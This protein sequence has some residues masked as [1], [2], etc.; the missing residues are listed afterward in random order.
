MSTQMEG[1]PAQSIPENRWNIPREFVDE[2]YQ[3]DKEFECPINDAATILRDFLINS[4]RETISDV[5]YQVAAFW[6]LESRRYKPFKI[7]GFRIKL[8]ICDRYLEIAE[9]LAYHAAGKTKEAAR[10]IAS[11][12]VLMAIGR[13]GFSPWLVSRKLS[14]NPWIRIA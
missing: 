8:K 3:R 5:H 14:N 13:L 4:R 10:K 6:P 11:Y 1:V 2:L 9:T 7:F 12:R